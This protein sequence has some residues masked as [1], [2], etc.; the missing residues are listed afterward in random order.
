VKSISNAQITAAAAVSAGRLTIGDATKQ[1]E[2]ALPRLVTSRPEYRPHADDVWV[3]VAGGQIYRV[4]PDGVGHPVS[5]N[6]TPGGLPTGTVVALRFSSDGVRVAAVLDPADGSKTVWTGSLV[7][8][9]ADV[10]IDSFQ[11]V[12]PASLVVLDV[13]WLDANTIVLIGSRRA[14]EPSVWQMRSDGSVLLSRT[15]VGLPARLNALAVSA[16]Q[17]VLVSASSTI[18]AYRNSQWVSYGNTGAT[19]GDSPFYVP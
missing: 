2:V 9:G 6:P 4:G 11:P 15:N 12:T 14:E 8:S 3:G 18:W 17:V 7:R 19:G 16:G 5:I 10:R 1:I 13:G